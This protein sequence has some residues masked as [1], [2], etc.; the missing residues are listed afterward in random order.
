MEACR[1]THAIPPIS[2]SLIR[3]REYSRDRS[4]DREIRTWTGATPPFGPPGSAR[5]GQRD[6]HSRGAVLGDSP[7]FVKRRGS[8]P[9]GVAPVP[10]SI[11]AGRQAEASNDCKQFIKKYLLPAV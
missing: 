6:L 11:P 3:L 9:D 10:S 5:R 4:A 1:L 8:L 7:P 2:F